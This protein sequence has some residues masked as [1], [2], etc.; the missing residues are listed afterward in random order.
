MLFWSGGV[1]MRLQEFHASS[2][3][4]WPW[5]GHGSSEDQDTGVTSACTSSLI[6]LGQF[7]SANNIYSCR[8]VHDD[9]QVYREWLQKEKISSCHLDVRCQRR[10]GR[11]EMIERQQQLIQDLK[12]SISDNNFW[13]LEL[14][15]L[16]MFWTQVLQDHSA[17]RGRAIMRVGL[18]NWSPVFSSESSNSGCCCLVV[19]WAVGSRSRDSPVHIDRFQSG[20]K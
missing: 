14:D 3:A 2:R 16:Q 6:Y 5:P 13:N 18:S 20:E 1:L 12:N 11:L 15:V 19:Q 8:H 17:H 10:M 9:S 7:K 4:T